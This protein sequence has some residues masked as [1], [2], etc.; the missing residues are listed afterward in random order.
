MTLNPVEMAKAFDAPLL[1]GP[2]SNAPLEVLVRAAGKQKVKYGDLS[3]IIKEKA[4]GWRVVRRQLVFRA[5]DEVT[6]PKNGFV[7][8]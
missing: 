6:T 2:G 5:A 1:S 4:N 3:G 7:Y 8:E